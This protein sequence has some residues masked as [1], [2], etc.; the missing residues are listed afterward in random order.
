MK[1]ARTYIWIFATLFAVTFSACGSGGQETAAPEPATPRQSEVNIEDIQNQV[2]KVF[3][4]SNE[5]VVNITSIVMTPTIFEEPVPQ[6][7]VGTGFVWDDEG[8]IVTNYHVVQEAET[9]TV[10]FGEG[11]MLEA[12]LIGHDRFTDLAVLTVESDN[13]PDPLP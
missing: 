5:S 13:I 11:K 9:V 3:A 6:Q 12:E 4:D 7:G 8:H 1:Q 10:S 2:K